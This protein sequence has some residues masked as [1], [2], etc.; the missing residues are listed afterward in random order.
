MYALQESNTSVR[1]ARWTDIVRLQ[2][3]QASEGLHADNKLTIRHVKFQQNKMNVKL[4]A[5]TMSAPVASALKYAFQLG[6]EGFD[7]CLGTVNFVSIIDHLFDILT[8]GLH[9]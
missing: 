8:S 9:W 2:E 5:Q 6:C 7:S 1:T 4:A 3:L